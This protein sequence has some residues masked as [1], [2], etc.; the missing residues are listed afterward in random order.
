VAK[1]TQLTADNGG[2]AKLSWIKLGSATSAEIKAL[3]DS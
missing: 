1:W 2:S 3:A